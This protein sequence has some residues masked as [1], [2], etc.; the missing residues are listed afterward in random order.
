MAAR[1]LCCLLG[2]VGA[3]GHCKGSHV[4]NDI[5]RGPAQSMVPLLRVKGWHRGRLCRASS[6]PS[7]GQGLMG[8][9]LE[10]LHQVESGADS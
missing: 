10:P 1:S 4:N 8:S 2:D 3:K 9:L 5:R 6:V 7:G